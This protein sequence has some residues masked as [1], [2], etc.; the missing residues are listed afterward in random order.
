[1]LMKFFSSLICYDR[2]VNLNECLLNVYKLVENNP[3]K[4]N[5]FHFFWL[6]NSML[7]AIEMHRLTVPQKK[8]RGGL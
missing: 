1:M 8:R 4:K 7:T 5:L 3:Y 6:G 2:C